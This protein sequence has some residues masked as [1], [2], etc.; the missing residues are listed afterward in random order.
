MEIVE[1]AGTEIA[2]PSQTLH[3]ADS[4]GSMHAAEATA[5]LIPSRDR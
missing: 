1:R 3:V 4:G 5:R 2:L